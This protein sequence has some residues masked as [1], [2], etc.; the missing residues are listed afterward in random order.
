MEYG[1]KNHLAIDTDG[2]R[3]RVEL[4]LSGL[5]MVCGVGLLGYLIVLIESGNTRLLFV[6]FL[7]LFWMLLV[8][9]ILNCVQAI[10]EDLSQTI[11]M[12]DSGNGLEVMT[13]CVPSLI[14]RRQIK[15]VFIAWRSIQ[16]IELESIPRK[17][18]F[19]RLK[20]QTDEMPFGQTID[21]P[22]TPFVG[23]EHQV[24]RAMA[25]KTRFAI[26]QRAG[27]ASGQP[28]ERQR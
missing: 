22:R 28:S 25:I 17:S 2:R 6:M 14:A 13:Y 27:L 4:L 16:S 7:P 5:G 12:Q 15:T 8:N 20:V 3:E 1:I 26:L 24:E 21:T 23:L 10:R 9:G 18:W 19:V 11:W